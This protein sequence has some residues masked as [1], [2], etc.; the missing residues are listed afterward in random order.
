MAGRPTSLTPEARETI[1]EAVRKG[2]P[3][4]HAAGLARI[5][6]S[7]VYLWLQ[8]NE[9]PFVTFALDLAEA[10]AKFIVEEALP[11]INAGGSKCGHAWR[12]ERLDPEEFSGGVKVKVEEAVETI[13]RSLASAVDPETLEK[14]RHALRPDTGPG[15][16]ATS[17]KH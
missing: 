17:A 8:S 6:R 9:E 2:A 7:T 13:L 14:V 4:K 16:A 10:R 11:M 15:S 1:L 3:L 5:H 12:L